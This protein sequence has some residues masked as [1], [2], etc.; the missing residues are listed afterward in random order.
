MKFG[1]KMQKRVWTYWF[2]G[3]GKYCKYQHR[4]RAPFFFQTYRVHLRRTCY[5]GD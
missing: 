1:H 3:V 2:R 4:K 5:W